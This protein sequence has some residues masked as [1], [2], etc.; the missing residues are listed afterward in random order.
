MEKLEL[1]PLFDKML[2]K[3]EEWDP[4]KIIGKIMEIG[5]NVMEQINSD[6]SDDERY[7]VDR[8]EVKNYFESIKRFNDLGLPFNLDHLRQ[9]T[10]MT[11]KRISPYPHYSGIIIE[12]ENL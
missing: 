1:V 12:I 4:A 7:R 8:N 11:R 2:A 5:E 9:L 6:Y 3:I 10:E